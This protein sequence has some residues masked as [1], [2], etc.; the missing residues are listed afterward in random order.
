[1][2]FH[3]NK[4]ALYVDLPGLG[5]APTP[6]VNI[7]KWSMDSLTAKVD[8]TAMGDG[9]MEYVT[10]L[11]DAKGTFAGFQD[12]AAGDLYAASLDGV[13]RKFY[14]YSSTV[15]NLYWYGT[16]YFDQTSTGGATEAAALTG[17]F[18]AAGPILRNH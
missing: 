9:N 6:V 8:V 3:G 17:T 1:M 2:R 5:S 12:T 4:G 18:T 13:P 7:S 14:L 11:P 16:A 10:G 15:A